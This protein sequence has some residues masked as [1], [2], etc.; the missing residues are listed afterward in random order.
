ME[1]V[2]PF[3][4]LT[5]GAVGVNGA[6]V[7]SSPEGLVM[8]GNKMMQKI[9]SVSEGQSI[10]SFNEPQTI[11]YVVRLLEY[12]PAE[13][14]LQNR[15]EDVLGDQRRLSMVAQTAFAEVFMDWIA[16]L[17]KDLEDRKS[18]V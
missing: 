17:E 16:S 18:V 15:F 4:W 6:P 5:Q 2:G 8:P 11:C 14:E 7:L 12:K 10:A 3:T 13:E 1:E 9:F